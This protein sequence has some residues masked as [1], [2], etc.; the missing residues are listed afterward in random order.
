MIT[1]KERMIEYDEICI[2]KIENINRELSPYQKC[3]LIKEVKE[4]DG[5]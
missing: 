5:E 4:E 1:K 3:R 2:I